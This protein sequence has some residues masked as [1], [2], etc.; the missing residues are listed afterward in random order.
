MPASAVQTATIA[1]LA[2]KR[3]QLEECDAEI[4]RLREQIKVAK[5]RKALQQRLDGAS[6]TPYSNMGFPSPILD[7]IFEHYVANNSMGIRR[8]YTICKGWKS[9][10]D[11]SER[12]WTIVYIQ[13]PS[14]AEDI[15]ACK[16]YCTSC[17]EK[18]GQLS[19]DITVDYT[20]TSLPFSRVLYDHLLTPLQKLSDDAEY[21]RNLDFWLL[22]RCKSG[23]KEFY[24]T[25]Q[26]Y[27]FQ[28]IATLAGKQGAHMNRWKT[29]TIVG[30]QTAEGLFV[31]DALE[32]YLRYP[33]PL[34]EKVEILNHGKY[35]TKWDKYNCIFPKLPL[36]RHLSL[37]YVHIP[38][39][40]IEF[41][42]SRMEMLS[43]SWLNNEEALAR[44]LCC[45]NLK[46]LSFAMAHEWSEEKIK[47]T[48]K[49]NENRYSFPYLVELRVGG[50]V[51]PIF[52]SEV[53][54]PVVRDLTFSDQ[55]PTSSFFK[56]SGTFTL[57]KV[58]AVTF[59]G[60]PARAPTTVKD[61]LRAV[62]LACPALQALRALSK[63]SEEIITRLKELKDEG[64]QV[65]SLSTL[66]L[67]DRRL[68]VDYLQTIDLVL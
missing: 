40:T 39:D 23:G 41:D 62:L 66:S 49:L 37:D 38:L 20:N 15:G 13:V 27:F 47:D 32:Q 42:E 44:I 33:A 45:R 31:M 68:D 46:F 36:V 28:P 2:E 6:K 25:Y 67:K 48:I 14:K 64:I 61:A 24:D 1:A 7:R 50:S 19:L 56:A 18:S 26:I 55:Y 17:V 16:L 10:I 65:S 58:T 53:E 34:L 63:Y 59:V 4:A 51:P 54:L 22:R 35:V 11:N 57:P 12:L 30:K 21:R 29:F 5:A 52:W 9:H 8:L 43:L 3:R 60:P